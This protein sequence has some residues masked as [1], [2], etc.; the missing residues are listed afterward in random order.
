MI[1]MSISVL[2]DYLFVPDRATQKMYRY[3]GKKNILI[4]DFYVAPGSN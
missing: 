3:K 4:I 1:V 2:L